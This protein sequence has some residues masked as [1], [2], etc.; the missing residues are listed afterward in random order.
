MKLAEIKIREFAG[1]KDE[2]ILCWRPI[3]W[4]WLALFPSKQYST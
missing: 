4:S 2:L 3:N 1:D